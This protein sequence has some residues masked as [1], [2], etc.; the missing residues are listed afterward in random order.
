VVS[1]L[2]S[3]IDK[4]NGTIVKK[5][6]RYLTAGIAAFVELKVLGKGMPLEIYS[7][8]KDFGRIILRNEGETLAAGI[9][10]E[11]LSIHR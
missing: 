6:P 8:N 5:N 4:T 9:V 3:V 10:K 11:L 7:T 1:K 2:I